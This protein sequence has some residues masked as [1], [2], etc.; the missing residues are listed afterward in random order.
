[1][2]TLNFAY[3]VTYLK[4]A[5][6]SGLTKDHPAIVLIRKITGYANAQN[7]YPGTLRHAGD[8]KQ[9]RLLFDDYDITP[10]GFVGAATWCIYLA[11]RL[12]DEYKYKVIDI[13]DDTKKIENT[14]G[15]EMA[16]AAEKAANAN[17]IQRVTWKDAV[18]RA[19]LG[20]PILVAATIR[21]KSQGHVAIVAPQFVNLDKMIIDNV[22]V[23][24]AGEVNGFLPMAEAFPKR[25]C[26]QP[27]FYELRKL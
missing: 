19:N 2:K 5:K 4:K 12:L 16:N 10:P 8:D 9:I 14:Q 17:L 25:I 15:F 6:E 18:T 24:Q 7:L 20:I 26:N 27:Q 11:Y 23:G 3:L 21:G 22:I 1:M 13:L